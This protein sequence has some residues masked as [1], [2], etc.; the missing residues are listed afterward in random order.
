MLVC[1]IKRGPAVREMDMPPAANVKRRSGK[2]ADK[3]MMTEGVVGAGH[4]FMDVASLSRN[5]GARYSGETV[6]M[7]G[8]AGETRGTEKLVNMTLAFAFTHAAHWTIAKH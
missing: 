6:I 7:R 4:D 8:R 2:E 1:E 5:R 3:V